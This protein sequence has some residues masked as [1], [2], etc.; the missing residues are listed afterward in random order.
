MDN[1]F[2]PANYKTPEGNYMKLL[3]GEN[4]FRVLSSAIV[5]YEYWNKDNKPVRLRKQPVTTP[6]DIRIDNDKPSSIKHFWAFLVYSHRAEKAQILEIT[7]GSIQD[8]IKSLVQSK[9]WGD[10]K[11]YDITIN[12]NGSGLDTEY[13]VMPNP[14]S[15]FPA[16]L[17]TPSVNLEA[18]F[19]GED[20]FYPT[21]NKVPDFLQS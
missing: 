16:D 18:L 17:V 6:E 8:A 1:T 9:N 12:R 15:E 13:S 19:T 20:P 10:P 4:T 7:Q 5:G 11:T 21:Q 14:K 2:L 3:E